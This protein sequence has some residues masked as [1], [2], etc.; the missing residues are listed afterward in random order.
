MSWCVAERF[1]KS[2][3]VGD[4]S[5]IDPDDL[6]RQAFGAAILRVDVEHVPG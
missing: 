2:M 3:L 1:E 5:I 4:D 6:L